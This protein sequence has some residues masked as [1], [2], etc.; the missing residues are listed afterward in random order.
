MSHSRRHVLKTLAALPLAATLPA[1]AQQKPKGIGRDGLLR[2]AV[3]DDFAPY[4]DAGKGV[5]VDIAKALA[6][7]LG[8]TAQIVGFKAGDDMDDDLRNMVWK[9]HYLRGQ[10]ADVMMRVPVEEALAQANDKVRIFGAYQ[11]ES[12]AMARVPSRVPAPDGSSALALEVFTREKIGVEG[13]TLADLFLLGTLNGRLRENVAHYRSVTEA[14]QALRDGAVSAV[15]ATRGQL[16]NALA[17]ETR[18][19]IDEAKIFEL[20]NSRWPVGMAVESHAVELAEA[21]TQALAD[22]KQDGT[23]ASIFKRYHLTAQEA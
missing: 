1:L 10:P 16:E 19:A 11:H 2:V 22:L 13:E 8:L 18:F 15:L 17:G 4:S 21:L 9:G 7:K 20:K 5:D 12:I 6:A 14:A 3:Y 23:L